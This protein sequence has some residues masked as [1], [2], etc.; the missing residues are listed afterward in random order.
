MMKKYFLIMLLWIY[1]GNLSC[2]V[3]SFGPRLDR[4][5]VQNS[6]LDE[7]SGLTLSGWDNEVLWGHND[8]GNET[9]I[10][11]LSSGGEHLAKYFLENIVFRDVEDIASGEINGVKYLYLADIGDNNGSYDEI[12]VYKAI[13]PE[14]EFGQ[15]PVEATISDIETLILQYPE[16]AHYD[17]ETIFIDNQNGDIYIVTKRNPDNDYSGSSDLVFRAAYPQSNQSVNILEEIA[18]IEVETYLNYGITGGELSRSGRELLLKTYSSVYYWEID[19]DIEIS[20][21]LAANPQPVNY[22][23][24]PQGEAICWS[25]D[26]EGY[27]SSSEEVGGY[28]ARLSYYA[29]LSSY[30]QISSLPTGLYKSNEE[31][32][33]IW[34]PPGLFNQ[35]YTSS[36]S[37]GEILE[38]YNA[39]GIWGEDILITTPAELGLSVG[40]YRGILHNTEYNYLSIEFPIIVEADNATQMV[41]PPN[42]GMITNPL[43]VF[44][45]EINPGVP[46]Y[47]VAV[48]DTPFM[49]EH[50]ENGEAIVAGIE[51]VWQALTYDT[52]LMYGMPDPSGY[53]EGG[54]PP[55]I[56]GNEYNWIVVN[57]Y[58]NDPLLSSK[59]VGNPYSFYYY[60]DETIPSVELLTPGYYEPVNSVDINFSWTDVEEALY[61]QI[62]V[63]E[64]RQQ[65]S[66]TGNYLVWDQVTTNTSIEMNAAA[67]LINADYNWKVYATNSEEVSSVSSV[68]E[69][70]HFSYD[71]DVGLLSL[72][73]RDNYGSPVP[74][75]TAEIDPITGSSDDFPLAVNE[76]G[77]ED[78]TIPVGEYLLHITKEGFEP[79]D[80]VFVIEEGVTT[81]LTVEMVYSPSYFYGRVVDNF[82]YVINNSEILAESN[83]YQQRN[84]T[85][86]NG[87][88]LISVLPATWTLK[89]G[90][91]GWLLQSD[92]IADIE[93]GEMLQLPDLQMTESE[94]TIQG[95]VLNSNAMPMMRV[96]VTA[97]NDNSDYESITD[98]NG[99]YS[100]T[101][102]EFGSYEI[103]SDKPG[104]T[105]LNSIN[106]AIS[107]ASPAITNADDI[108]LQ[109]ASMINGTARNGQVGLQG[110]TITAVPVMGMPEST[111]TDNY[112]DYQLNLLAG[113][114]NVGAYREHYTNQTTYQISLATGETLDNLDFVLLP[115]DAHIT[116]TVTSEGSGLGDVIISAGDSY[117]YSDEDGS[118]VLSIYPGTYD[119]EAFLSGYTVNHNYRLSLS[120]DE[121]VSDIDFE[122]FPNASV[123]TGMTHYEGTMIAGAEVFAE[124][125][126]E[127]EISYS[128]IS[129]IFGEYSFSLNHGSYKLWAAKQNFVCMPEDTLQITIAPGENYS[130]ADINLTPVEAYI[131][132]RIISSQGIGIEGAEIH[133]SYGELFYSTLSGNYGNFAITVEPENAYTVSATKF[134]YNQNQVITDM[135]EIGEEIYVEIILTQ[136]PSTISGMV[137]D[138]DG[139]TISGAS[140]TA[141]GE[142]D[143]SVQSGVNGSWIISLYAGNYTVTAAK[144]GY[145]EQY[146]EITLIP[147]SQLDS[148]DFYLEENFAALE[149]YVMTAGSGEPLEG[150]LISASYSGGG[151]S[152]TYTDMAGYYLLDELIAGLYESITY[153][154]SGY[155]SHITSNQ[156]LPG[157]YTTVID[158]Q[159]EPFVAAIE[160][161]V[162][163]EGIGMGG[164]TVIAENLV[165]GE[166]VY[167]VTDDN[168]YGFLPDVASLVPYQVSVSLTN[169][170]ARDTIVYPVPD[171]TVSVSFALIRIDGLISGEIRDQNDN[172]VNG[173]QV[174]AL[175]EDG[176][177]AEMITG[178]DGVYILENLAT[179]REYELTILKA[180]YSQGNEV[181]VFLED[182]PLDIDI[183][184]YAHDYEAVGILVDQEDEILE[185]IQ[186]YCQGMLTGSQ[187]E[188]GEDG[189]FILSP[190]APFSTYNF[191]TLAVENGYENVNWQDTLITEDLDL[192]EVIIPVHISRIL[193]TIFDLNTGEGV[194]RAIVTAENQETGQTTGA[195]SQPDG[196]YRIRYLYAGYYDLHV[197]AD[198]YGTAI[199][200][201]VYLAHRQ[202]LSL[203]VEMQYIEPLDVSGN[204]LDTD[205][206]SYP[207]IPV[208]LIAGLTSYTVFTETDG[209]FSFSHAP[210]YSELIITT[211]LSVNYYDN[212]WLELITEIEDINGLTLVI[213]LHNA[214]LSGIVMDERSNL[215]NAQVSLATT[216]TLISVTTDIEGHYSFSE[217]YEGNY[218]LECYSPGYN[219]SSQLI[220]INDSDI[221]LQDIM[222][223]HLEDAISGI[224]HSD[225]ETGLANAVVTVWY[226][227]I[228]IAADTSRTGGAFQVEGLSDLEEY[229]LTVSKLG[230]Q[231]YSHPT[232]ITPNDL[233][234]DV[235]LQFIIN[236]LS[237]SV[238]YDNQ[239]YPEAVI[240]IRNLAG[241]LQQTESNEF[242]D[243]L[244]S[245]VSGYYDVWAEAGDELTSISEGVIIPFGGSERF[246]T[247][248]TE[249]AQISGRTLYLHEPKPGVTVT[250]TNVAN[251]RWVQDITDENGIYELRGLAAGTYDMDYY[252]EGYQLIDPPQQITVNAGET[253]ILPDV[254]LVFMQNAISGVVQRVNTRIGISGALVTISDSL[255]IPLDVYVTPADG[256]FLFEPL[257]DGV[258]YLLAQ[259]PAYEEIEEMEVILSGGTA[260]PPT[261]DFNMKPRKLY[262]YGYVNTDND[263]PVAG[264]EVTAVLQPCFTMQTSRQKTINSRT[265]CDTTDANGYY[266]IVADTIGVWQLSVQCSGYYDADDVNVALSWQQNWYQQNFYLQPVV[267]YADIAGTV[268][269]M[270]QQWRAFDEY[271]LRLQSEQGIDMTINGFSP[272]SAYIFE[273]MVIPDV[274]SLEFDGIYNDRQYH[275]LRTDITISEEIII[276]ED[277][278]FT[279]IPDTWNWWGYIYMKDNELVALN[280]VELILT[281]TGGN[282]FIQHTTQDGFYL[283]SSLLEDDYTLGIH[284]F[285]DNELFNFTSPAFHLSADR[286]YDHY[287]QYLLCELGIDIL[288]SAEY[289]LEGFLLNVTG[290]DFSELLETDEFGNCTTGAVL[291]TGSYNLRITPN[292]TDSLLYIVPA[293]E[294]VTFDTL[295]YYH[296][297]RLLP[298]WIDQQE[299]PQSSNY[300][301]EIPF[302]LYYA[303]SFTGRAILHYTKTGGS[304]KSLNMNYGDGFFDAVIPAQSSSGNLETWITATDSISGI[305]YSSAGYHQNIKVLGNGIPSVQYSRILPNDPLLPYASETL[306]ELQIIDEEGNDLSEE[307]AAEGDIAWTIDNGALGSLHTHNDNPLL[308]DFAGA[309]LGIPE[310]TGNITAMVTYKQFYLE[311]VSIIT[312]GNFEVASVFVTG[313][314]EISNNAE[315][316]YNV[317]IITTDG[318]ELTLPYEAIPLAEHYGELHVSDAG[319]NFLPNDLFIGNVILQ[320]AVI[321]P[322]SAAEF[323]AEYSVTVYEVINAETEAEIL[324]TGLDCEMKLYDKMLK[325]R[326]N[327]AKLYLNPRATPPY[328]EVDIG[329][330][331]RSRVF[332]AGC[333]LSESTFAKMPGLEFISGE[334]E[335]MFAQW[336][337]KSLSWE[338]LNH[339][340]PDSGH[341][342]Q[343]SRDYSAIT[344]SLKLGIY[345]LELLPNPFTP[346]DM[347]GANPGLQ[348]SFRLSSQK[349]RFVKISARIYTVNGE[350]VR[351][352]AIGQSMLKGEY[353]AGELNTLY[354]DGRTDAGSMARNGRYLLHLIAEDSS[355]SREKLRSIVLIK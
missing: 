299:I 146:L 157:N 44:Q 98:T 248:L 73:V 244:F 90:K 228:P 17:A 291:H 42:G 112:G 295:G 242:A 314:Y 25:A 35:L 328:E 69:Q 219:I 162:T 163:Y 254:E 49:I 245:N 13:E 137:Y 318:R 22:E 159:L 253:V 37:G 153:T 201:S 189:S 169:Y 324:I 191:W 106:I 203:D 285:Y 140:V 309:T 110:V 45:W 298:L 178:M 325:N 335:L 230:F 97:R 124:K 355:G 286:E 280:D 226:D 6:E 51:T 141:V 347:I 246:H 68:S 243:Y 129:D 340:A 8:S 10:Y 316:N 175:S 152:S 115:N 214:S 198:N 123:I 233:L 55:M 308:L 327:Q 352:L 119:V 59:V 19:P 271:N 260:L 205:G 296:H 330:E 208:N 108:I 192:G 145:L 31:L 331:T 209:S 117:T 136:L 303:E 132:G 156:I 20:E 250:A 258:Y 315:G 282:E 158:V 46:Y 40:V 194:A 30:I 187:A 38:N 338:I 247:V 216:D 21:A 34:N 304:Q 58:G 306:F 185:G 130:G 80:R 252:C 311:I 29:R 346:Y 78:K 333:D 284:A 54:A 12:Y 65:G 297:E 262:I 231:Q 213:D 66:N 215:A 207:G 276:Q 218:E 234:V 270:D 83:D 172:P 122:L 107:I 4:G 290:E 236:S 238:Y 161:E 180:G 326:Q 339:E 265:F 101:G 41:Y 249:A 176:Y 204:V 307:I 88:Y 350:L 67:I 160:A 305:N 39:S 11:A 256:T 212:D 77:N 179:N 263:E 121:I 195:V 278:I 91:S 269:I 126:S 310:I 118:Y 302:R 220:E 56:P 287:F 168:G 206:R 321:D 274:F 343:F 167:A 3:I 62:Q 351:E 150:V 18:E 109:P 71:I 222:L 332:R 104:Y 353:D 100:F 241:E 229:S 261:A 134:G 94:K 177:L 329:F 223:E 2:S 166:T 111:Q 184:I 313:N 23:L 317:Q 82:G 113:T 114:Y 74:F 301:E 143:Y 334:T 89:A 165:S 93:S 225:T 232:T 48:S 92:L 64:I 148:L 33:I 127:G 1:L 99:F 197:Y 87:N 199:V 257:I 190:L 349:S 14:V 240:K 72:H 32:Q 174:R 28:P 182:D 86:L 133:A 173:V 267:L 149:G 24:E 196:S 138:Q 75:A 293:M 202:D 221:L 76:N 348:I 36:A 102:V 188:S 142:S 273:Q 354:W 105:P 336:N 60:S 164:A 144:P 200:D 237:G 7:I 272:D 217:L 279:W 251:G 235:N 268:K 52:A 239:P 81:N 323:L 320:T 79:Q 281:A 57:N 151:G 312:L 259:H 103:F 5:M 47:L 63:F 53:F 139:E 120:P 275:E 294:T 341:I 128:T 300:D 147:G 154:R 211:D 16:N 170:A 292:L 255:H 84:V 266:E 15:L 116:G 96:R 283:F 289:G 50:D 277:F 344:S 193:G 322:I 27:Y 9:A 227:N 288:N 342:P 319:L 345:D 224:V 131:S 337:S 70:G 183:I 186:V 26:A 61:Y 95:Y 171:D 181:I 85:A 264:A 135:L 43:P 210:S 155:Y 125:Q